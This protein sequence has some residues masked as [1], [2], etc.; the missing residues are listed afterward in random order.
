M[1]HHLSLDISTAECLL[2]ISLSHDHSERV[3]IVPH[4]ALVNFSLCH[5]LGSFLTGLL[6]HNLHDKPA[7]GRAIV[8]DSCPASGAFQNTLH[9]VP[10]N[11]LGV[12]QQRE[13][14]R[15]VL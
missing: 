12:E 3:F 5:A 1:L 2:L 9:V 11:K 7:V 13:L 6:C 10:V 14:S 4:I 15:P 8:A